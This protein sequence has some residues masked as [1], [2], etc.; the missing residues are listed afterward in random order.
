MWEC[1]CG[2]ECVC[3]LCM[4]ECSHGS[5]EGLAAMDGV[6]TNKSVHWSLYTHTRAVPSSLT[7]S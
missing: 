7:P 3:A 1:A 4:W 5:V 2:S 6:V